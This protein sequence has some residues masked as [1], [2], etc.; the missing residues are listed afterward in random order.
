M[1]VQTRMILCVSLLF[2]GPTDCQGTHALI[3]LRDYAML[4][5]KC[6]L[7][8]SCSNNSSAFRVKSLKTWFRMASNAFSILYRGADSEFSIEGG[9]NLPGGAPT[10]DFAKKPLEIEKILGHRGTPP[11]EPPL[12]PIGNW[13]FLHKEYFQLKS[14]KKLIW[15]YA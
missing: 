14:V 2:T 4:Y 10:Y 6:D 8:Q 1:A 9:D 5:D 15:L 13:R 3:Y 7:S 11:S 12:L